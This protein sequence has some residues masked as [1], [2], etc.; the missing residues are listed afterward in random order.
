MS[1]SPASERPLLRILRRVG[2]S[3]G[4]TIHPIGGGWMAELRMGEE[5]RMLHGYQLEL[6][7]AAAAG[8]ATDKAA[9]F[10]V[11][12]A[13]GV[14]AVR[15]EVFLHPRLTGYAPEGGS[16]RGMLELFEELGRDAVV[17]DN[18]G[19]GGVGVFRA[20]SERSLEACTYRLFQRVHGLAMCPFLEI[21]REV[22]VLLLDGRPLLAIEKQ[23]PSVEGD[24]VSTLRTLIERGVTRSM[25][26]RIGYTDPD[27]MAELED[28]I[29]AG[30]VRLLNWRHNLGQGST[31]QLVATEG[32]EFTVVAKAA[33]SVLRIT[34][35]SVDV[36]RVGNE[37]MV[38]EV[39]SGVM[40]DGLM[41]QLPDG[42]AVAEM[43]YRAAL[44][45]MFRSP[46]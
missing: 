12:S 27:L 23:R 30:A 3:M 42:E 26:E 39:N 46:K 45:R 32:E 33:A 28:V 14:K 41:R 4:I 24:G 31:A 36:V 10:E 29:P 37:W 21:E 13:H 8:I 43:V 44:E 15:H 6:N 2:A 17:K 16:W 25:A 9:A 34:F 22:R 38:L 20:R 11:L 18:M 19:T 7:S 1:S 40:M 5:R 35:A